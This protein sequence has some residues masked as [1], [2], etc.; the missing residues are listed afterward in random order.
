MI[1]RET[2]GNSLLRSQSSAE[3]ASTETERAAQ[4]FADVTKPQLA[5]YNARMSAAS[6]YRGSPRW[7]RERIMAKIQY[8]HATADAAR[9]Y[10]MAMHDIA[11]IGEISEATSYAFDELEVGQIMLQA[12]E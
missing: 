9:A 10:E 4:W 6:A 7:D 8:R 12:A 11:T 1:Q 2:S 5:Q 3:F